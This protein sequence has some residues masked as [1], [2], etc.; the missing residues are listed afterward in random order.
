MRPFIPAAA[1]ALLL[2]A[3]AVA[4]PAP[5]S[6]DI[7]NSLKPNAGSLNTAT[8][9]IRPAGTPT[10]KSA[11]PRAPAADAP[12]PSIN[13]TVSFKSGSAILTPAAKPTLDALGKA[14]SSPDLSSF[15]FKVE[16]H[17]DTVGNPDTNKALSQARAE[18]V[19]TYLEK[20]FHIDASKLQP[21]GVG[22]DDLI[23]QTPDQTPEPRNRAVRVVNLGA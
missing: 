1:I 17:T 22:S 18:T 13:L 12:A 14:L 6:D 9:G 20:K 16:G 5:S 10:A 11:E 23:V 15:H 4:Q 21:V 3:S 2:T 8:R 7:I 19:A